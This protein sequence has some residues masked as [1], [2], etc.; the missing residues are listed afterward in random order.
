MEQRE[1]RSKREIH[2][3]IG[4]SHKQSKVQINNLTL[5]LKELEEE[6]QTKPNVSRKKEIIKKMNE[7]KSKKYKRSMKPKADSL[8]R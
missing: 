6:K 4:L 5:C 2:S 3:S 7:I 1:S 8:K